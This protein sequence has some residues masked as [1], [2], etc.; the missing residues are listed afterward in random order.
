MSLLV[1]KKVF[2]ILIDE[3]RVTCVE[4]IAIEEQIERNFVI[5]FKK[6]IKISTY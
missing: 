6:N 1:L 3:K 2:Q 4:D 5:K